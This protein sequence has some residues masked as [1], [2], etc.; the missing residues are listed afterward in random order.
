MVEEKP[1]TATLINASGATTSIAIWVRMRHEPQPSPIAWICALLSDGSFTKFEWQES[2]EYI[3]GNTGKLVA[4][5]TVSAAQRLAVTEQAPAAR[6]EKHGQSYRLQPYVPPSG[7]PP[8]TLE[9][10]AANDIPQDKLTIGINSRIV[11]GFGQP[12]NGNNVVQAEPNVTRRWTTDAEYFAGF[13]QV[14]QSEFNPRNLSPPKP[15]P[16][17]FKSGPDIVLLLEPGNV[18][19]QLKDS[20]LTARE[21]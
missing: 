8:R 17:D 20:K 2:Y 19:K 10:V 11:S 5:K 18:L 4:G 7:L 1:K 16:I 13:G 6:I 21:S 9:I 12:G 3:W 15:F 14:V